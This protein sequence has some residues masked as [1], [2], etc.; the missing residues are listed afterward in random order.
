M[1]QKQI[2]IDIVANSAPQL[3]DSERYA[4]WARLAWLRPG[5]ATIAIGLV[6][7][8]E[9][10]RLNQQF[11]GIAEPT[12]VLSFPGEPA[13]TAHVDGG[14][15]GDIAI[16]E[17]VVEAKARAYGKSL[18]ERTALTVVHAV[19]HL[20]GYGH[21]NDLA[22]QRMQSLEADLLATIGID[23]PYLASEGRRAP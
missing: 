15:I 9:M 23:D 2:K 20:Q 22:A 21:D 19:L 10:A 16:C 8:A 7:E 12:D 14:L 3:I 1:R 4:G 6:D 13:S 11:R 5:P 17:A 18:A